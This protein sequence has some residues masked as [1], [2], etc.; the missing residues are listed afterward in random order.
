MVYRNWRQ[1][2][3]HVHK[4]QLRI[5]TLTVFYDSLLSFHQSLNSANVSFIT[6]IAEAE[7]ARII[8]AFWYLVLAAA[9]WLLLLLIQADA[10]ATLLPQI[11]AGSPT[12]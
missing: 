2:K 8:D 4:Q 6:E 9:C 1:Q 7:A 10:A 11:R 12:L 5:I 3:E